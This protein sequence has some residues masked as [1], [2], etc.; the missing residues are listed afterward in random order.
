[1]NNLLLLF[2][3]V[4]QAFGSRIF[5][6]NRNYFNIFPALPAFHREPFSLTF[7]KKL[8]YP[9]S[10]EDTPENPDHM[11]NPIHGNVP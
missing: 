2:G 1:M 9:F 10:K 11:N 3:M 6:Q 4:S 8:C 7:R 5:A